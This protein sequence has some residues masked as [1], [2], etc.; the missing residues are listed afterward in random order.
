M[1]MLVPS[2]SVRLYGLGLYL[3]IYSQE[4]EP[5]YILALHQLQTHSSSQLAGLL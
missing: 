4:E 3:G 1:V 2:S 5:Y